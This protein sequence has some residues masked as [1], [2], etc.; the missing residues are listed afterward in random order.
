MSFVLIDC[1]NFYVSCERL[2]N[3]RLERRPV[4]VLSNNDG[5]VV[6][7][8]QEVKE[9]GIKMG[10]PFFKIRDFCKRHHILVYSSN[11]ALYGDISHRVMCILETFAPEIQIYSIDEAFLK[12]PPSMTAEELFQMSEKIRRVIKQWVGIPVSLGIA[13][14]KTLA[15]VA[16]KM[17]KKNTVGVFDVTSSEIQAEILKEFPVRDLWGVGS[18]L[19][20][21]LHAMGIYTAEEFREKDPLFIRRKLGVIGERM[22][23]EL[24][25]V[26]CLPL[27]QVRP[28]KSISHSRSFARAITDCVEL[29]EHL[30][31]Y[32]A[33]A[34]E[35]LREQT[36]CTQA[37]CVY[38]KAK[39]DESV[40]TVI[41]LPVATNDTAYLI[42]AAK[43]GLKRLFR[44]GAH[45]KKCGIIL[46]DLIPEDEVIPDLFLG[47]LDPKRQR[48]LQTIDALNTHLQKRAVFYGAMG[49]RSVPNRRCAN[50]SPPYTTSWKDLVV[51]H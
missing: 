48:L 36:S 49:V 31:S 28:K 6:A 3:P 21:K 38:L 51:V 46:F 19:Q 39:E 30:S 50:R 43:E 33:S 42:S 32:I 45:Y 12:Y 17:A 29:S 24:R 2:F 9:L 25:G 23:W 35:E 27:E 18:A 20:A 5:C 16:N 44:Q 4:L 13:P 34:C 22:L 47:G 8:S 15:K 37:L 10:E 40:S 1:N 26:S 41:S 7:R 11:Y 14:T